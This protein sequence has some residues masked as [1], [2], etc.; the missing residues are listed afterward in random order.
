MLALAFPVPYTLLTLFT[1]LVIRLQRTGRRNLPTYR[2]V[3]AEK[4]VS[5]RGKVLE[6]MGYF[7][8]KRDPSV[9]EYKADRV[10][11]WV[12]QGA[13]LS[14]TVAR[15]L[16]KSGCTGINF[17]K[18]IKPYT[19]KK[20]R[21]EMEAEAA[22]TPPSAQSSPPAASSTPEQKSDAPATK[23]VPKSESETKEG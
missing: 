12:K 11:H 1:M 4:S 3:V 2:I 21:K 5:V 8:P 23:E 6:S 9:L 10:N 19:K 7:L 13:H 18:F 22:A 15:L 20:K 16:K 17:D 14:D